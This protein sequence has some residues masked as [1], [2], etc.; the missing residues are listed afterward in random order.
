MSSTN[1]Y[2]ELRATTDIGTVAE[3]LLGDRITN[4]T[5]TDLHVDCPRHSSD[6]G[7]SLHVSL[8]GGVWHCF[9]CGR[10]GDMIHLAEFVATGQVTKGVSGPMPQSHREAR[11]TVAEIAGLP[12]LGSNGLTP[13]AI[14]EQEGQ[15]LEGERV[16]RVLGEVTDH[17]S[18]SL[19]ADPEMLEWL[20]ERYGF[21]E[22]TV[23]EF[24]IGFAGDEQGL[25]QVL[26]D[27]GMS[28][29]DLVGSGVFLPDKSG[30]LPRPFF[31]NRVVFPYIQNGEVVYLIG[32]QT[33]R[34]EDVGWEKAK[35]KKL[36]CFDEQKRPNVSSTIDN[37]VLWGEDVLRTSPERV[38]VAE[39]IT[40]AIAASAAGF[41]VVSPVTVR[42]KPDDLERVLPALKR[43]TEIVFVLDN[44]LSEIGLTAALETAEYLR[45]QEVEALVAELPLGE[46]QE[47]ARKGFA[48][49][50]G[51]KALKRFSRASSNMKKE[52]LKEA[53]GDDAEKPKRA[54]D[55]LGKAKIDLAEWFKAGGTA[56][57]FEDIL[58]AARDPLSVRIDR[59]PPQTRRGKEFDAIISLITQTDPVSQ[60]EFIAQLHDHTGI[61]LRALRE[62]TKRVAEKTRSV[63]HRV[64]QRER[65]DGESDASGAREEVVH[66]PYRMNRGGIL[67]DKPDGEGTVPVRLTNFSARIVSNITLDDGVESNT[68]L[69]IEATVPKSFVIKRFRVSTREFS[70]LN[71]P[72]EH[73][74][75]TA[76]LY[77][78]YNTKDR[79][80][81]A[82]QLL[83]GDPESR[84]VYAHMGWRKLQIDGE[85][86]AWVY[87]NAHGAMGTD[88]PV[89]GV[90]VALPD[91]LSGYNLTDSTSSGD[92]P[93]GV[94]DA[95]KLREVASKGVGT[96]LLATVFRAILGEADF[97]VHLEGGTGTRKTAIAG[98]FQSFF[99][100]GLDAIHLPASWTAT[101]NYLEGLAFAAKD[102]VLTVDDFKPT[103]SS[104]DV[105]RLHA[106]ADRVLR[107]Q[108]NR[109]GRGRMRSDSSL[110]AVKHPRGIIVCTGEDTPAGESLR[111]R[112]FILSISSGSIPLDAL[113]EVQ[114]I[115]AK[116]GY[117]RLMA[118]FIQWLA[119]QLDA[120]QEKL[121]E[122]VVQIRGELQSGAPHGRT[123]TIVGDLQAAFEVFMNFAVARG[124]LTADRAEQLSGECWG[125]LTKL[126][127]QQEQYLA[128][129]E[130]AGAFISLLRAVLD[131]G[132]AHLENS[133]GGVPD[134]I[135]GSAYGWSRMVTST[136][137]EWLPNGKCVGWVIDDEVF[138]NP[139]AA[140][141]EAKKLDPD[142]FRLNVSLQMLGKHLCSRGFLQS[143]DEHRERYTIRKVIGGARSAVLHLRLESL[144]LGE[145]ASPDPSPDHLPPSKPP[146]HPSHLTANSPRPGPNGTDGTAREGERGASAEECEGRGSERGE[147]QQPGEPPQSRCRACGG[148]EHYR[149]SSGPLWICIKCHPPSDAA[150]VV[151]RHTLPFSAREVR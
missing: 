100:I 3:H 111:A 38:V 26:L 91:A 54:K 102:A 113:T 12:P 92:L 7:R 78:G 63:S 76:V 124:E 13:E 15:R 24:R 40:D 47:K 117:T 65:R 94:R 136:S 75:S 82:I 148:G 84:T 43:A 125:D 32:R 66:A 96:V 95:L 101:E 51:E 21:D 131:S 58:D 77:P 127:K 35:Y 98:V 97:S 143:R 46:E 23:R 71:W 104:Q 129:A 8:I 60:E 83:S 132:E 64:H 109:S 90:E 112:M 137:G 114:A 116:G 150:T 36:P 67:F 79:T 72:I 29:D 110:R 145:D 151:E 41:T 130:P 89:E 69:E 19:L 144:G 37:G 18:Q 4:R 140:Y 31:R 14:A 134:T 99:G 5:A 142:G 39:G 11:D 147:P 128:T 6:S 108:G 138:L 28:A 30:G 53:L 120:V 2:A 1:Y 62:Q 16:R 10:G 68:T 87:L 34:T 44:E 45:E 133:D 86:P 119:P 115:A 93:V 73:L 126:M 22:R 80:R 139:D 106:K 50:L 135:N 48:G 42:F 88:G 103:G 61:S 27:K 122:R 70:A 52:V 59:L 33:P 49:L 81:A 25:V 146:A 118:S 85:E 56:V 55:L 121:R 17:Y 107:A 123:A 74:G 20:E 141:R 149:V 105:R 9:A 57:E